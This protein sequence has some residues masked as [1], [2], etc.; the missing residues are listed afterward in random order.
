MFS[1][2]KKLDRLLKLVKL[3]VQ[4]PTQGLERWCSGW[5]DTGDADDIDIDHRP[6]GN[7]KRKV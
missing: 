6:V 1:M 7:P 3:H 5:C 2:S 4:P